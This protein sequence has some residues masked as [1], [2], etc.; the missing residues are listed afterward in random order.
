M[1]KVVYLN[2]IK[3]IFVS[4]FM[5]VLTA[6]GGGS[7]SESVKE[8]SE[9]DVGALVETPVTQEDLIITEEVRAN[10]VGTNLKVADWVPYMEESSVQSKVR[11]KTSY[12][13][14][15]KIFSQKG[16]SN[17]DNTDGWIVYDN[18][19]VG[20]TIES[21]NDDEKG[22]VLKLTGDGLNNGYVVGY[23]Y[24]KGSSWNDTSNRTIK[25]SMKYSEE[26]MI[27]VRVTTKFGYRY[28]YYT[29]SNRNYGEVNYDKPHYIHN[30]LGATSNDGTWRTFSRD[31]SADLKRHQPTNEII[32]V[33]GLFVR[34][35]GF[36][37]D[38]E[39]L[40]TNSE[41]TN[42]VM[43]EDAEDGKNTRWSVYTSRHEGTIS[44]IED[45]EKSSRVIELDGEG[46]K[47]GY[48]LGAWNKENGWKNTINKEISWEMNYCENFV[49][50]ISVETELGHRFMTY[51]SLSK[52]TFAS[53]PNY[54]Q[55]KKVHGD[56]TY[57]HLGLNPNTKSCSWKTVSRNLEADLKR[58]EP[59]NSINSV[60][61]FLVR[62]SGRFD[63]IKTF[64]LDGNVDELNIAPVAIS[65]AVTVDEDTI[66]NEIT[67]VGTDANG[68]TL[69]Y[70]IVAQ[71]EHGM[72]TL[73]G[74]IAKYT[75]ISNYAG[76][77]NFSFKVNDG[78]LDSSSVVVTVIVTD[79]VEPVVDTTP[80]VITLTGNIIVEVV[81][82]SIYSDAG[83][84]A[85]DNKDGVITSNIVT[86]NPVDTAIV[87]TYTITYNVKDAANNQA[88]EVTRTVKVVEVANNCLTS[89]AKDNS[90]HDAETI[91]TVDGVEYKFV[92]YT[93]STPTSETSQATIA[94]YGQVEGEVDGQAHKNIAVSI[95]DTYPDSAKFQIIIFGINGE[96]V[97]CGTITDYSPSSVNVGTLNI[98]VSEL[99]E[100]ALSD[101]IAQVYTK[102]TAIVDLTF[103]NTGGAVT[104]CSVEP[105]LPAGLTVA[106]DGATCK[107][108]GT[109]TEVISLIEYTVTG[110]N[111]SGSD[112]ATVS[113][114][115]K[116]NEVVLTLEEKIVLRH[117]VY[118]NLVFQDSNLTW[119]ADLAAHAQTWADYLSVNYVKNED[120]TRPS[121][122]ATKY[123]TDLHT[124]D[125]YSEGENIAWT[126]NDQE[127][128]YFFAEPIDI[129][130][131]NAARDKFM[132]PPYIG[133]AID[134]W[135]NEKAYYDYANNTGNGHTVGH[136]TQ[137]VWKNT[138]KVGCGKAKVTTEYGGTF[139]V[140][141][142]TSPGN[143]N[144][145]KP[146]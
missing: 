84:T 56:Y 105:T 39:L 141:R 35:S 82:G 65:E 76:T 47:T 36:I 27:Y 62:G 1:G 15:V 61:A 92:V 96:K 101:A 16:I 30:G 114:E 25:W 127:N 33:D 4:I 75:P 55:G 23:T 8:A 81:Q 88:V 44:N 78:K 95:N 29:D 140:C 87:G 130:V 124:E 3:L 67:L 121:P 89:I 52:K 48:I 10:I 123:Q 102:D 108:S 70:S 58:Y 7:T 143:F 128:G 17:G 60:N 94:V 13:S 120:G 24:S 54:G 83:A 37:D 134:S 71:P 2:L 19:P 14:K 97:G 9:N 40:S 22:N 125:D 109:P 122:H 21:V 115:V 145:Q 12:I 126:S 133:G 72:V 51:S 98:E 106:K 57:I 41:E 110:S 64:D 38:V 46:T 6:C 136:Y 131:E 34:G 28:L 68:D 142:Y 146:Y 129:S 107:I 63:T 69:T 117:N 112:T 53:N 103:S 26:F 32:S 73:N 90:N 79:V 31:L 11:L 104:T 5:I 85:N 50:Y 118:R 100:P 139:V 135:A 119:D 144:G 86:V 116:Y 111:A 18:S 45:T 80:P 42:D 59:N 20:A 77:D 132:T 113:I 43:Y 137:V 138:T 49:V 66:N 74:N 91:A 99:E 93:D